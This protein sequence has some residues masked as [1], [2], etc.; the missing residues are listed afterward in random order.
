[1][2]RGWRGMA[3]RWQVVSQL[4]SAPLPSFMSLSLF[5]PLVASAASNCA[6]RNSTRQSSR[7]HM[8]LH[9]GT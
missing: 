8:G 3:R 2:E 5:L 7:L 9:L 1:M 6:E 4:R